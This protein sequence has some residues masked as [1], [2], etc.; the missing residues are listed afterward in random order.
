MLGIFSGL[1]EIGV[2]ILQHGILV[3]MTKLLLEPHVSWF[4]VIFCL[5]R[6]L[7]QI[8]I[9]RIACH[10]CLATIGDRGSM[11]GPCSLSLFHRNFE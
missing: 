11:P 5:S 10:E 7:F 8:L 6:P 9:V 4:V 3:A 1:G 2:G